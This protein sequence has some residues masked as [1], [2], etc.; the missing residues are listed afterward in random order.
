MVLLRRGQRGRLCY[1]LARIV[2]RFVGDLLPNDNAHSG[3][4][5]AKIDNAVKN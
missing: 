2:K 1:G 4:A 3:A 5:L